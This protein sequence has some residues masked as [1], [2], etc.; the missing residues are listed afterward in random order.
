HGGIEWRE[1]LRIIDEFPGRIKT[2]HIKDYSKEK[3]FNVFLGE[4]EVGW[5][6]LLKKLK[7]SGK[8]EWYIVEQEAFKGYTSI[9]AIKI[10]FLRLKEIMKEIGQ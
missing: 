9:E 8:I 5:K 1:L 2:A 10:D 4:G 6:E 7:D 3:E